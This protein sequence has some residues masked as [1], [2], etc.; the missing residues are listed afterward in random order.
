MS[1]Y[2]RVL[3]AL[4]AVVTLTAGCSG[5]SLPGLGDTSSG[6]DGKTSA[7]DVAEGTC[8]SDTMLGADPQEVLRLSKAYAVPYLVAAH[9]LATRPAFSAS[10]D[11]DDVHSV[12]VYKVVRLPKLDQ[13][14]T[15]Y[16]AL[17]RTATPLYG[18]VARSVAQAC[19]TKPLADAVAK[20]GLPS[21]VMSPMLPEGATLGWAPASPDRWSNGQR[22]FAC[23]LTWSKPRSTRYSAV[24]T[25]HFP[26]GDRTC[27]D[28]KAL[29]FVDCARKHDRERIA[30]IEAREAVAAGAFPGPKAIR[31]GPSGRYLDVGDARWA[32]LDAA[33]TAYLRA[34]STTKKLT[35]VANV[36]VDE[37]PAPGGSYPIY[38]EA[39]TRPDQKSLVT[40]GSVYDRG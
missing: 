34:I 4:V 7:G 6:S 9:A 30:V 16:A 2:A 12:E 22:V 29:V 17:L 19:T 13:Q 35:G 31:N 5:G 38:C 24:F 10:M 8:W 37:W 26:T 39:D 20:A 23:T 27:I 28:T 40:E 1:P 15:D 18:T 36:D 14:L 32:K 25:K 21:A 33:C 3:V 11:C